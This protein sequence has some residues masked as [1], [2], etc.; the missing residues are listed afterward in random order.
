[1][2]PETEVCYLCAKPI[3]AEDLTVEHVFPQNLFNPGDRT[4]LL[5]LPAHR[6]CNAS[7][8][9]DDETFRLYMTAAAGDEPRAKKL[10]K[11][12]V[13][14]SV[15]RPQSARYKA[16]ILDNV[17]DVEVRTNSGISLGNATVLTQDPE[18]IERVVH[19]MARGLHTHL[20]G[21]ILPPDSVV[22]CDLV[23]PELRR[24]P[25]MACLYDPARV[26]SIGGGTVRFVPNY[27]PGDSRDAHFWI[28]FYD[29]IDFWAFI[30]TK[31]HEL[32]WG[33][34]DEA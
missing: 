10:W 32:L 12:P 5:K 30:G 19:R 14:R 7:Y 13:M 34:G 17:R 26:R 29:S 1:V 27:Y 4:D 16:Y 20:T 3:A 18:R 11:G 21:D 24:E 8:S 9:K 31:S 2:P 25:S 23:K 15:H 28:V 22:S 33:Q 6:S